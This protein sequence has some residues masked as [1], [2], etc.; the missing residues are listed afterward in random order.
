R[1]M[2]RTDKMIAT[3]TPPTLRSQSPSARYSG[4][5]ILILNPLRQLL[6]VTQEAQKLLALLNENTQDPS[7]IGF[8][9][10]AIH[11]L[12]DEIVSLTAQNPSKTGDPVPLQHL[13]RTELSGIL[14]RGYGIREGGE[15]QPSRLLILL[16]ETMPKPTV[17]SHQETSPYRLTDRQRAIVEGLTHGLTNKEIA[18][19]LQLSTHT[20]KEY[21]R[22][23]M[24]KV[25]ATSRTGIVARVAG[26]TIAEELAQKPRKDQAATTTIQVA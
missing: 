4:P 10:P 7:V 20:V 8:L 16:E 15:P 9:P 24:M 25:S 17:R 19:A 12:C 11:R 2:G 1:I 14:L 5:G 22:Q 3:C 21:I 13:A 6:Y 23:L 26:L 18:A